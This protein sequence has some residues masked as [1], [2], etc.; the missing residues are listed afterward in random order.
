[1][2]IGFGE[3]AA[4]A[5]QQALS[6]YKQALAIARKRHYPESEAHALG[7]IGLCYAALGEKKLALEYFEE[8]LDRATELRYK[9]LQEQAEGN[10][11]GLATSKA[12]RGAQR[13]P[14]SKAHKDIR[15]KANQQRTA[16]T[17]SA[18]ETQLAI[19]EAMAETC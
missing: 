1:V 3:S 14:K 10:M 18:D 13:S 19:S 12:R 4:D 5:F 11:S 8:Q 2:A 16:E 17:P 7:G 6:C 15:T 9:R